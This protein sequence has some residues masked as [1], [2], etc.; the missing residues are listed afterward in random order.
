MS[1]AENQS[2]V[3]SQENQQSSD[4]ILTV[5]NML[6]FLRILLILPFVLM[7]FLNHIIAAFICL[8]LSGISDMLDG[9]L[10]RLLHQTSELGK[11]LDPIADKL[12][13][14]AVVI[15]LGIRIPEIF[16]LM[17]IL[18]VKDIFMIGGG[19]Y[20]VRNGI[21]P[22]QS[23]WYGKVATIMFY[24]CV[25]S[26]V[27]YRELLEYDMKKL[28][29]ILFVLTVGMMVFALLNYTRLFFRLINEKKHK[30]S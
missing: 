16:P 26:V 7:F 14:L 28:T 1:R 3:L 15:C 25:V 22:P 19:V 30:G 18:I 8:V 29:V 24:L 27:L 17:I 23:R 2:V 12:T 21:T 4:M 11:L 20:L 13:L 9:F 5:P 10:A 6:S